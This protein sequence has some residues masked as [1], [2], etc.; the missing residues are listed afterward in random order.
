MVPATLLVGMISA[1]TRRSFAV[2]AV[3]LQTVWAQAT[4]RNNRALPP[5]ILGVCTSSFALAERSPDKLL[6]AVKST[7]LRVVSL[8]PPHF[9]PWN[10]TSAGIA[11]MRALRAKFAEAGILIRSV[12]TEIAASR[13]DAEISRMLAMANALD[14]RHVAAEA[15]VASLARINGLA[16]KHAVI[17][18]LRNTP[19]LKSVTEMQ[20]AVQSFGSLGLAPDVFRLE[21]PGSGDPVAL[22]RNMG[23]RVFEI[24]F[25][26]GS[27]KTAETLQDARYRHPAIPVF[28]DVEQP[29][30]I[31]KS[32]AFFRDAIRTRPAAPLQPSRKKKG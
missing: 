15:P 8:A 29:A 19:E 28:V 26:A 18:A 16:R 9:D 14:I 30:A 3:G 12:S 27:P 1:F 20:N 31:E 7:G 11:N 10:A 5:P 25:R 4:N 23:G 24:R 22:L 21:T 2:T 32:V 13:T 17:V 6:Q